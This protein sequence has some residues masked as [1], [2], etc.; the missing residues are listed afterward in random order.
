MA[1]SMWRMTKT[2]KY[3][4]CAVLRIVEAR[5]DVRSYWADYRKTVCT[6]ATPWESLRKRCH[7]MA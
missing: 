4:I 6:A 7:R 1:H 3:V 5:F 2:L